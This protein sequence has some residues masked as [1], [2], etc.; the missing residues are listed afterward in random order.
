VSGSGISWAI[1]K[2]ASRSKQIT[3]PALHHSVFYRPNALPAAQP[4]ASKHL[5]YTE[6]KGNPD[7]PISKKIKILPCGILF[8]ILSQN[9]P[10]VHLV[11]PDPTQPISWL[12]HPTRPNPIQP[13]GQRNPRTTLQRPPLQN[14]NTECH[15][16]RMSVAQFCCVFPLTVLV[17]D[18]YPS[19]I[20]GMRWTGR[21]ASDNWHD[22]GTTHR[23]TR[24]AQYCNHSATLSV[25]NRH[26]CLRLCSFMPSHHTL[27][28][29]AYSYYYSR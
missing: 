10:R 5:F 29:Q 14:E 19:D 26:A 11:W 6:L 23:T 9:C 17:V 25:F 24:C 16:C 20:G 2:S 15:K 18:R 13:M 28:R 21:M 1:C 3:R 4:T 12:T 7:R 27:R 22:T 8:Q